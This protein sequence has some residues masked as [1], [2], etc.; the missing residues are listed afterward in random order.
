MQRKKFTK[1]TRL[2]VSLNTKTALGRWNQGSKMERGRGVTISI[3]M[4]PFESVAEYEGRPGKEGRKE[5][6]KEG[7][8]HS[9][10]FRHFDHVLHSRIRSLTI[11]ES[12]EGDNERG[13]VEVHF[14]A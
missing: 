8:A 12:D 11:H 3:P 1:R 7:E 10:N 5:G 13:F 9:H 14:H 6:R 2:K 4:N